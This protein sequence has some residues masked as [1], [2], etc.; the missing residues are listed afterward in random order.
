MLRN[1]VTML[2][3]LIV[4]GCNDK[5]PQNTHKISGSQVPIEV[6]NSNLEKSDVSPDKPDSEINYR[7]LEHH[8][9]TAHQ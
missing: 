7:G 2:A 5:R 6:N 8:S 1:P 4:F 9:Q 3:L